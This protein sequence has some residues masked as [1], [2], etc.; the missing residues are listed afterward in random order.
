MRSAFL[1][2]TSGEETRQ[3]SYSA[4]ADVWKLLFC[5]LESSSCADSIMFSLRLLLLSGILCGYLSLTE[6]ATIAGGTTL[7]TPSHPRSTSSNFT[8]LTEPVD[9][10]FKIEIV[11]G[12]H[13]FSAISCL[14]TAVNVLAILANMNY[15]GKIRDLRYT[16]AQ[17]P[18]F[19]ITMQP[20]G[21]EVEI[22]NRIAVWALYYGVKTIVEDENSRD[23]EIA[24]YWDDKL[25][26]KAT[27]KNPE[28]PK[29]SVVGHF[30][31]TQISNEPTQIL[32]GTNSSTLAS[33]STAN[34][35]ANRLADDPLN[36][37]LKVLFH[38]SSEAQSLSYIEVFITVM[39]SL[40][41]LAQFSSTERMPFLV[42]SAGAGYLAR[43][44]FPAEDPPRT[45]PPYFQVR[46]AIEAVR[47]VPGWQL[48]RGRWCEVGFALMIG[49]VFVG[50]GALDKG[51]IENGQGMVMVQE[52]GA[53]ATVS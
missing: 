16:M 24:I 43:M 25:V 38:S 15:S 40:K 23:C 31:P 19:V 11:Y 1:R 35:K 8:T 12:T 17:Y 4:Y 22:E 21:P 41:D 48:T 5:I 28:H 46:W 34:I 51:E 32:T 27:F 2:A 42:S 49:E 26:A 53:N 7:L 45:R 10:R 30:K 6:T 36:T 14:M 33:K 29:A 37:Q 44:S 13:Q 3:S 39:A 47:Q 52:T 20:V 9:P 50:S 18:D